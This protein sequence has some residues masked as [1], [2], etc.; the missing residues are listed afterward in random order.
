MTSHALCGLTS[1]KHLLHYKH[2]EIPTDFKLLNWGLLYEC[3]FFFFYSN[4]ETSYAYNI[5]YVNPGFL[6]LC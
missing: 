4:I 6:E 3:L 1:A 5:K 2:M